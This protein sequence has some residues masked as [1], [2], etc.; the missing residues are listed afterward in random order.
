MQSLKARF[1]GQ[2]EEVLNCVRNFGV[3]EAMR[4]YQ[5]LDFVAMVKW[6]KEETGEV[7]YAPKF[8]PASN[9]GLLDQL[10][11]KF[12]S[13]VA[14]KEAKIQR[15]DEHIAELEKKLAYYE[16]FDISFIEPK[17]IS[18]IEACEG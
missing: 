9:E 11:E 14:R 8:N 10:V 13:F 5:V 16:A 7:N 17:L 18:V 4:R 12:A 1:N 15:Q 2:K 6:L 3:H